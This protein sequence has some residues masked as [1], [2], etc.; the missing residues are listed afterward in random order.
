MEC[1]GHILYTMIIFLQNLSTCFSILKSLKK[2]QQ[3]IVDYLDYYCYLDR[4][5]YIM[6]S[7]IFS[8][9]FS[10]IIEIDKT[11]LPREPSLF[12]QARSVC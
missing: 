9:N 8:R 2:V 4:F 6:N 11:F 10:I 3:F 12:C 7:D 1:I 5:R